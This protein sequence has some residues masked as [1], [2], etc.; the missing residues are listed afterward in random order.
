MRH[1]VSSVLALALLLGLPAAGSAGPIVQDFSNEARNIFPLVGQSFTAEDVLI[2]VVG[3]FVVDFTFGTIATDTTIDYQLYA[4]F[5]NGGA[6]LGTRTFS[7]L[8]DG[9]AGYA[10]VSFAGIPLVVGS[11]YTLFLTNDTTQW[12]VESAFSANGALYPNGTALLPPN[13]DPGV[14]PRD[15]R[16]H[17]LPQTVPEPTTVVLFALGL[18]TSRARRWLSV[19]SQRR[20]S[21]LGVNRADQVRS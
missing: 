2:G 1:Q 17:I 8:A 21:Q 16:F 7:G 18:A 12:G 14:P 15:L 19:S 13:F 20:L 3:A 4:G 10:D 6:L 5:G 11:T 9:F